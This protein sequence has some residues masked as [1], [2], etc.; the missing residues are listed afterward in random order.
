VKK[1]MY[2]TPVL[3][4]LIVV[5]CKLC[6]KLSGWK[7]EGDSPTDKKYVLVAVPH[8]SNWDFPLALAIAFLY[9][10]NMYWMGKDSLFKGW[11][12]PIMR[13]LGGIPIN[14]S[15]SNNVVS[16]MI[17]TFN[18]SDSLIV[19]IPPEGTRSQVDK[20]KTGFYYI[21][22]G[23]N[24]PIA[25]AFIDYKRKTGGFLTTFHPTG[26]IDRDIT[27]MRSHY[28]GVSGKHPKQCTVK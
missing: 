4:P 24:V 21:A 12:G 25:L 18:S 13:W 3:R 19:T 14:R 27:E 8:T 7:L 22:L 16:Q 5:I 15:S 23:A 20:W 6:L 11:R 10:F 26:N 17:D 28:I 9:Q 1:T 2:D